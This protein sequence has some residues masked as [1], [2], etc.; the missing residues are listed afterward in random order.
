MG[1]KQW[2][3]KFPACVPWAPR[4]LSH[5]D[6]SHKIWPYW[7]HSQPK[8]N[9]LQ[10]FSL[11]LSKLE[12]A[13]RKESGKGIFMYWQPFRISYPVRSDCATKMWASSWHPP[14]PTKFLLFGYYYTLYKVDNL[15]DLVCNDLAFTKQ[16]KSGGRMQFAIIWR[17]VCRARYVYLQGSPVL[18]SRSCGDSVQC[19]HTTS[20]SV[21]RRLISL[22]SLMS[23]LL[24][25]S[26][27]IAI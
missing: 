19:A 7:K 3:S 21:C 4:S 2:F 6:R 18:I 27:G 15:L 24:I 26:I 1:A 8:T 22:H 23:P 25:F 11:T 20:Q 17:R 5:L 10:I 9:A 14:P 12:I 16:S 13:N